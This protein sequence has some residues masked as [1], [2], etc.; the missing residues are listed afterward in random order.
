[1]TVQVRARIEKVRPVLAAPFPSPLTTSVH[2]S[3]FEVLQDIPD[4]FMKSS[5]SWLRTSVR[6]FWADCRTPGRRGDAL[7]RR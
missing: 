3:V 4:T 1:M 6:T 7:W 2:E 5:P